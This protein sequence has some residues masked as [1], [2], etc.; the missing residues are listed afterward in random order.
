MTKQYYLFVFLTLLAI[1]AIGQRMYG[2]PEKKVPPFTVALS[3][4]TNP[5]SEYYFKSIERKL[6]DLDTTLTAEQIVSYTRYKTQTVRINPSPLDSLANSIYKL[7]EDKKYQNAITKAQK[8]L[9]L[10]PNNISGH[11]EIS[12][13]YKRAGNDRLSNM[14]FAMMVKIITSVL[15][16]GD[17]SYDHPFLVNNFW[18]GL[19]IYEAAFQCKPT[20]TVLM[21]DKKNRLL[22]AYN[23]YSRA[24]DEILIRYSD[25]SHWKPLLKKDQYIVEGNQ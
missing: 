19:S 2:L 4:S 20:K 24:M 8:L 13:A 12:L 6:T 5:A 21:A 18:E 3:Q 16:Y 7:N 11:K 22:G 25:L 14:H 15:K 1:H 17:G 9:S 10:S 23:G